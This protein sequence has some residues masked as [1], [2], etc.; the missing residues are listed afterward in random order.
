MVVV[1]A[2]EAT[3]DMV[4][5]QVCKEIMIH[6]RNHRGHKTNQDQNYSQGENVQM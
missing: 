3:W 1:V 5:D 2:L 4:T 6:L